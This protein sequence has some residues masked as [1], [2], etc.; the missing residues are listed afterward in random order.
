M[1]V[2]S[3]AEQPTMSVPFASGAEPQNSALR[4]EP[5]ASPSGARIRP[6]PFGCT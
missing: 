4:E 5:P 2:G 1:S 3:L 6:S